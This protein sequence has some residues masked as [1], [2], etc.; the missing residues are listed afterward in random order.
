MQNVLSKGISIRKN[1]KSFELEMN[2]VYLRNGKKTGIAG[3]Q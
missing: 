1:S 3:A 2:L